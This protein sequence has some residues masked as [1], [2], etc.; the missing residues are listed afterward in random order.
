MSQCCCGRLKPFE[1]V[2]ILNGIKHEL[3]GGEGAMC[4]PIQAC[5]L[6]DARERVE[7]FRRVFKDWL[8]PSCKQWPGEA[9]GS[10]P[11]CVDALNVMESGGRLPCR[12]DD[13]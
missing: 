11:R 12:K 9:D 1:D 10:C 6:R 2:L 4:A 5:E 3:L 7:E 13:Q 8:C